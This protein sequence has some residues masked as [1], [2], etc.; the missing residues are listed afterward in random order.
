MQQRDTRQ[1]RARFLNNP[2]L[3]SHSIVFIVFI[4]CCIYYHYILYYCLFLQ[5]ISISDH[6]YALISNVTIISQFNFSLIHSF[7]P[8]GLQYSY[9]PPGLGISFQVFSDDLTKLCAVL[10]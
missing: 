8:F 2:D 9:C 7:I 5:P 6:V 3:N 10:I 4:Y 1:I